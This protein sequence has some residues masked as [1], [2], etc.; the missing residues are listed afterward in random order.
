VEPEGVE[1]PSSIGRFPVK[2][3]PQIT[4]LF[5]DEATSGVELLHRVLRTLALTSWLRRPSLQGSTGSSPVNL[6]LMWSSH[7]LDTEDVI[8]PSRQNQSWRIW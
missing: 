5:L 1:P 7:R 8:R 6:R 4:W 2:L 3:Q